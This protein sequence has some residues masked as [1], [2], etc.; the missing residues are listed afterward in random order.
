MIQFFET[1]TGRKFFE[2]DVPRLV[3]AIEALSREQEELA[4]EQ[5]KTNDL[6]KQI[7]EKLEKK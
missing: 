2:S 7:Y 6:L 4:K 5:H 3:H 1:R